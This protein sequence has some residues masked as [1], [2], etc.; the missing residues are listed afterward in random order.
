MREIKF[1]GFA[2][3]KMVDTQWQY[4]SGVTYMEFTED[5]AQEVGRTGDW[6]VWTE[7]GWVRVHEKSIGQYTGLKDKNDIEIFES[8]I[9]RFEYGEP[10]AVE[11][12]SWGHDV[13]DGW[14][15]EVIGAIS[16]ERGAFMLGEHLLWSM[17]ATGLDY[18][19]EVLGN[20]HEHPHLLKGE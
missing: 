3:E 19:L 13:I 7:S 8:D 15:E 1:R 17:E 10:P 9:V 12:T 5:Y 4:G 20:V 6:Y 14:N 2:V 18:S 11:I 16:Y